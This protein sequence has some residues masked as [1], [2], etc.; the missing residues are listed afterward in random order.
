MPPCERWN[1]CQ[2]GRTV[3]AF[4]LKVDRKIWVSFFVC[5]RSFIV[6]IISTNNVVSSRCPAGPCLSSGPSSMTMTPNATPLFSLGGS[7]GARKGVADWHDE[8]FFKNEDYVSVV[9]CS[10]L[11]VF[12]WLF[13]SRFYSVFSGESVVPFRTRAAIY[14]YMFIYSRRLVR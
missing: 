13:S 2:M 14:K 1:D 12:L 7:S 8:V 5:F 6:L 11:L 9:W 10:C 4:L 3:R